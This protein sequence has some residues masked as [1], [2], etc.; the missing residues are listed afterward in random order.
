MS[1]QSA[2]DVSSIPGSIGPGEP[3]GNAIIQVASGRRFPLDL[4]AGREVVVVLAPIPLAPVPQLEALAVAWRDIAEMLEA[5]RGIPAASETDRAGYL[6]VASESAELPEA[7]RRDDVIADPQGAMAALLRVGGVLEA[8]D[9]ALVRADRARR[10]IETARCRSLEDVRVWVKRI[11]GARVPEPERLIAPTAPVLRIPSVFEPELCA[12]LIDAWSEIGPEKSG[13]MRDDGAGG[14]VGAYN[15]KVKRR[16][17]AWLP[18]GPMRDLANRRIGV[19]MLPELQRVYGFRPDRMERY[20]IAGY[21][22]VE[23]GVFTAHRDNTTR[24]TAHRQIAVSI[25][26]NPPSE[27][28]GGGL[29]FPEYGSG[30]HV[31]EAGEALCFG[32][33]MLHEVRPVTRGRRNVFLT[34]L[35]S[36]SNRPADD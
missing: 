25:N 10:G 7:L 31:P 27:Y 29:C 17:D 5:G 15:D 19:R 34:F 2:L 33:G 1:S 28:D 13:F 22:A 8:G 9:F 18:H 3:L 20:L 21:D 36:A 30:L 24:G 35:Y 6:V 4:I 32:C 23:Q 11:I 12:G 14:T 16:R 26:L